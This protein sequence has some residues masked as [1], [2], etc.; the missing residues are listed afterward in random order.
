MKT[1][2]QKTRTLWIIGAAALVFIIWLVIDNSKEKS[3]PKNKARTEKSSKKVAKKAKIKSEEK[4]SNP[5]VNHTSSKYIKGLL[6]ADVYGNMN[7]RGFKTA[8][9]PETGMGHTWVSKMSQ[10]DFD[11]EVTAWSEDDEKKVQTI[12]ASAFS[13]PPI[14]IVEAV[15]FFQ[16]V[17]TLPYDHS[18]PQ[19]AAK[20]V[21]D[22]FEKSEA[23]TSIGG[24]KFTLV[25]N[26]EYEKVL[27]MENAE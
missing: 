24:V 11:Y 22:N 2:I 12:K 25:S 16:M 17:S 3:T 19:R 26:S 9:L 21:F 15:Q 8:L 23:S 6:P 7:S 20:W 4:K 10:P 13:K 27:L 18:Q 14:K 1:K 5:V